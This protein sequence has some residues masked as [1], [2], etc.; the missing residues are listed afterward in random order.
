[1]KKRMI[2]MLALV[3]LVLGGVFG[4]LKFTQHMTE[5]YMAAGS[6]PPQTVSTI[7]AE[8]SQWQPEL[9]AVGSLRAVNGA[10]L[11]SEVEGIVEEI[12][13]ESGDDVEKNKI[14]LQLRNAD[15]IAQLKSLQAAASLAETTLARDLRQL[16]MQA[17]SQAVVDSDMAN[18]HATKAQV[19]QQKAVIAKKTIRAPFAGHLGIRTVD[20]GQYLSAGTAIV[21]LQ[22]LDPIYA[23]FYLPE[24]QLP[25]V[26]IGQK[27]TARTDARPDQSFEGKITALNAKVDQGTRNL[28]IRATIKN[29][30]HLLLPGMFAMVRIIS[31]SP[32]RYLTL[33]QTAITYN[34]YGNTV[35]IVETKKTSGKGRPELFAKQAF[36]T[37]GP[38]RGDQIAILKGIKEGDVIV[39]SGQMKLHNGSPVVINNTIQPANDPNPKP[40]EY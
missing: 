18:V 31:G 37:T 36:V 15:E 4:W 21:T 1:M 10:D 24:Q 19:E 13:F 23:D 33:P 35:F 34:P 12:H 32:Q 22:Q 17:V 26:R 25:Q 29:P 11:S 2:I 16:K 30:K 27:V 40:T 5:K 9:K 20:I 38:T 28:L 39:T 7:K 3:G 14:L 6:N 8:F